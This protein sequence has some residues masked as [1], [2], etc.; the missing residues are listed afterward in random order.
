MKPWSSWLNL[1]LKASCPLCNRPCD[2]DLCAGCWRALL[3]CQLPHPQ[4]LWTET[5]PVFVWGDYRGTLKQAIAALKYHHQPQLACPL[6][7]QLGEAWLNFA[8]SI[9]LKPAIVPI[10]VHAERLKQRGYNQAELLAQS[11]CQQTQLPLYSQALT[12]IRVT[13]KQFSLTT[14]EREQNLKGVFREGADC[15]VIQQRRL[16]VLILD[17]IYTTG[18]TVRSAAQTLRN[19]GVNVLGVV[20]IAT[21]N[22]GGR[23]KILANPR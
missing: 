13:E 7:F 19:Q 8:N 16:P 18:A 6:G 11:F 12:R 23:R 21:T 3:Q 22:S 9:K 15:A 20:A 14:L 5:L 1:F 17:D 10:P 2:R 4:Q